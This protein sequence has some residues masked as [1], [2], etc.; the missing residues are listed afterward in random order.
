MDFSLGNLISGGVTGIIGTAIGGYVDYKKMKAKD[1]HEALMADKDLALSK[2]EFESAEKTSVIEADTAKEVEAISLTKETIKSDK[3]TYSKGALAI[4][5][6][7][8]DKG[9]LIVRTLAGVGSF[10]LVSV[11]ILRGYTRPI[12][13][14]GLVYASCKM[15]GDNL[16]AGAGELQFMTMT[17]LTYW[18]GGRQLEKHNNKR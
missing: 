13:T 10:G 7:L 3:A 17:C 9:G 2:L 6:R 1:S 11:D 15:S 12:I 14:I 5:N 8:A 16:V 4:L 18:F